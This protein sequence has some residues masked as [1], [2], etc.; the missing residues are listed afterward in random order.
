M[1]SYTLALFVVAAFLALIVLA[2]SEP[3]E[4]KPTAL[5]G[6]GLIIALWVFPTPWFMVAGFS[7]SAIAVIIALATVTFWALAATDQLR[8]GFA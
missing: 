5:I 8:Q 6:L 3:G 7:F 4:R 2:F 1:A